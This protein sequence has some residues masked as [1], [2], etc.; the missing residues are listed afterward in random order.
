MLAVLRNELR[1]LVPGSVVWVYGS[2]VTP[3]G[4]N[5]ASDVD[6]AFESEPG[7]DIYLLQS[8][9]SSAIRREADLCVLDQT[10][11]A[12]EIRRTG[13]KWIV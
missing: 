5:E 1:R 9:L 8:L 2:L 11:L 6:V 10:R 13:A 7:Q 12:A 3:G 4:F